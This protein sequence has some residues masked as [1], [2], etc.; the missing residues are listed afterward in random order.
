MKSYGVNV[1]AVILCCCDLRFSYLI[2]VCLLNKW[3]WRKSVQ[4]EVRNDCF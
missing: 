3:L 4:W 2:G 1:F